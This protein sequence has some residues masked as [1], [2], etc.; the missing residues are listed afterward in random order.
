[1][2]AEYRV[3]KYISCLRH[4]LTWSQGA[5]NRAFLEHTLNYSVLSIRQS[6]KM[7]R[8][9][10]RWSQFTAADLLKNIKL[11]ASL[12]YFLFYSSLLLLAMNNSPDAEFELIPMSSTDKLREYYRNALKKLS[13][14]ELRYISG[15][16]FDL[17]NAR[18]KKGIEPL[19]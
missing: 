9:V 11:A 3:Q 10:L 17:P 13:L 7:Q 5:R 6:F 18:N 15:T 4:Q 12:I 19:Q 1:M 2:V 16:L 8:L 14:D